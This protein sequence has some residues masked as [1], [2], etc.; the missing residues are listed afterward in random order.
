MAGGKVSSLLDA[1]GSSLNALRDEIAE[2]KHSTVSRNSR[3]GEVVCH[4]Q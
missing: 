3:R 2:L 1:A 4:F